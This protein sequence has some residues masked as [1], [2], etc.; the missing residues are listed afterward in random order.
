MGG[1][2]EGPQ[3]LKWIKQ[4]SNELYFRDPHLRQFR[5]VTW[6]L[7]TVW[8]QLTEGLTWQLILSDMTWQLI[9]SPIRD[10]SYRIKRELGGYFKQG[11]RYTD[12]GTKSYGRWKWKPHTHSVERSTVISKNRKVDK[13]Q[14]VCDWEGQEWV[15]KKLWNYISYM[16]W[17]GR[18]SLFERIL[19]RIY[20]YLF[21]CTE[22][23]YRGKSGN[24]PVRDSCIGFASYV[25][26][27]RL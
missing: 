20:L 14:E 8:R 1:E 27:I 11:C 24:V 23:I 4:L 7:T 3:N 5:Q 21:G 13:R 16:G 26:P 17:A 19:L 9:L 25:T 15:W 22:Y 10:H 12:S 18:C 2:H 6:W